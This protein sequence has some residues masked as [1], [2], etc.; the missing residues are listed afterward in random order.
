LVSQIPV[1]DTCNPGYSGG[2]DHKDHGS[3]PAQGI[4][5]WDTILKKPITKKKG[6]QSGSRCRPWIQSPVL[7]KK[8]KIKSKINQC[9]G[10]CSLVVYHILAIHETLVQ[11]PAQNKTPICWQF[12]LLCRNFSI[13]QF[14]LFFLCFWRPI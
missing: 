8:I 7:Q 3:E 10:M 13:S 11:S 9:W 5:L 12:A 1:T 2:R 4:S 6:W 14:L